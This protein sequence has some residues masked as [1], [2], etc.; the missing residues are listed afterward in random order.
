[1]KKGTFGK[2]QTNS[3]QRIVISK[4]KENPVRP[5]RRKNWGV[6][7]GKAQMGR[8]EKLRSKNKQ[9]FY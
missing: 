8:S 5:K 3:I 1:M 7:S 6:A 4:I 9:I 2:K